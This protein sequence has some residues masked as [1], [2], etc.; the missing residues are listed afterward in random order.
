MSPFVMLTKSRFYVNTDFR[1][2][3]FSCFS[4]LVKRYTYK[5]CLPYFYTWL[6]PQKY[7]LLLLQIWKLRRAMD[8]I[9]LRCKEETTFLVSSCTA[10]NNDQGFRNLSCKI[11]NVQKCN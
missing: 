2:V 8:N 6:F 5:H 3:S 4:M 9:T 1:C 10:N 11:V 7:N